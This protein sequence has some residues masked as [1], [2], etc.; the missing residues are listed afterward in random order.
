[1]LRGLL[2]EREDMLVIANSASLWLPFYNAFLATTG[3]MSTSEDMLA[4]YDRL[5]ASDADPIDIAALL[6]SIAITVQQ[7]PEH[8]ASR[9]TGD[10]GEGS[11]YVRDISE[12]VEATIV[13]DDILAATLEGLETCLLFIKL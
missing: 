10:A 5:Q 3:S 4:H 13:A 8:T 6:L 7:S 12:Q 2:P 1:M 9:A 11:E